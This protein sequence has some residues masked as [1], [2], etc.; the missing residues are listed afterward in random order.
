[1]TSKKTPTTLDHFPSS[2][3]E[4]REKIKTDDE[5]KINEFLDYCSDLVDMEEERKSTI[6]SK[7]TT[8]TGVSGLASSVIFGFGGFIFDKIKGLDKLTIFFVT[9]LYLLL[10]FCLVKSI[11]YS[12]KA[13]KFQKYTYPDA[14]DI[15]LL[16][17]KPVVEVKK[18]R[19]ISLFYSY[20]K[21]IEVNNN[22]GTFLLIAQESF[23]NSVFLL[24]IIS[25]TLGFY[26]FFKELWSFLLGTLSNVR[27]LS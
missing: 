1:M 14:N 5:G 23:R 13:L 2:L 10:S 11:F 16:S 19:A 20:V 24:A 22:K 3:K 8:L 27:I 21:N 17:D 15:F 25:V 26:I 12:I 6:E 9:I 7:A 18:E 4:I